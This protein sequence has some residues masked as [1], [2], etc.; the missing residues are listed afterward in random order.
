MHAMH[1]LRTAT[2]ALVVLALAAGAGAARVSGAAEDAQ[3]AGSANAAA[4]AKAPA[5]AASA[6]ERFKLYPGAVR[7][8]PPETE[9]NRQ[10]L[11]ALR[12]GT[13]I[14]AYFTNDSFEKVVTF[15]RALGTEYT[16]AKKAPAQKLP[17]GQKIRKT[18]VIL[19]GAPDLRASRSWLSVQHPFIGSVSQQEGAP[20]YEDIRDVTEIVV[21]ERKPVPREKREPAPARGAPPLGPRPPSH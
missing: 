20:K 10:F 11:D 7:Y 2:P 6:G 16:G 9:S 19:D 4:A 14:T 13:T 5:T 18:F 15:Y 3:A 12:P 21:T 8:V 17:N 1:I